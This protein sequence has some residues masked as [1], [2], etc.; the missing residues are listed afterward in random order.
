MAAFT[1]F[2][3]RYGDQSPPAGTPSKLDHFTFYRLNES[4]LAETHGP[5]VG[6]VLRG[7]LRELTAIDFD[8]GEVA[9]LA[10][11]A[12]DHGASQDDLTPVLT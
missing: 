3:D 10:N 9:E 1:S 5:E 8:S 7:L 6:R 12:A 2:E 4:G 11:R